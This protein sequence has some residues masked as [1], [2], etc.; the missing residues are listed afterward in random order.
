[1]VGQAGRDLVLRVDALPDAEGSTTVSER[2]ERLGGK[3]ANLA[4][5]LRQLNP[6][7]RVT[8]VAVL[9]AD[10]SGEHALG[11]AA[12]SGL[13]VEHVVRRGRTALL[14]DLVEADGDRRLLED[15]PS[16]SELTGDDVHAAGDAIRAADTVVLQLQQPA[17][18]LLVAA[19]AAANAGA[20]V[21]LDGA[22]E[23]T[24]RDEL[25]AVASVVR[26]DALEAR[27]LTGIEIAD[28]DDARRAA[29]ALLAHGPRV[30]AVSVP[31]EGDLVAWQGGERFF[32]FSEPDAVD[33]TGA[34]DAFVAGLV[35]ALRRGDAPGEAGRLAADAASSTVQRLGGR[36][37]LGHLADRTPE[38]SVS[39]AAPVSPDVRP[40]PGEAGAP[41]EPHD[42]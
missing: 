36:P 37:D 9:G 25:L 8:L 18:A 11:D 33:R 30:A 3:G 15:V 42:R 34:G 5:G 40:E 22:I 7:T 32:P 17:E 26:A 16:E 24:A 35:T 23:G 39:P 12:D 6:A 28:R 27:L 14:V 20:R 4:V 10:A 21:V 1:M 29:D 19:R 31:G 2:I 13:E 41:E 38:T